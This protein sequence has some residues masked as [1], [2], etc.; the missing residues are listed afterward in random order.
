MA[1]ENIQAMQDQGKDSAIM[2]VK[3]EKSRLFL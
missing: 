3:E 1:N 2:K